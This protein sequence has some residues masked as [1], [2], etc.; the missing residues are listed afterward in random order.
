[1]SHNPVG[2]KDLTKYF[3]VLKTISHILMRHCCWSELIF[4]EITLTHLWMFVDCDTI[5]TVREENPVLWISILF[6]SV[7]SASA[8]DIRAFRPAFVFECGWMLLFFIPSRLSAR[9][10]KM[11]KSGGDRKFVCDDGSPVPTWEP[12]CFMVPKGTCLPWL[13]WLRRF[14]EM[15]HRQ[16]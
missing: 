14:L 6:P 8:G 12:E 10:W 4:P 7:Y 5:F 16:F 15:Q 11:L 1:M 3:K 9:L 13:N 2:K